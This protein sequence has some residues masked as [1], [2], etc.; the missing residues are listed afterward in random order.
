[1][2]T[3]FP[4]FTIVFQE[5]KSGRWLAW[6]QKRSDIIANGDTKE[7][8]EKNLIELYKSVIEHEKTDPVIPIGYTQEVMPFRI[9]ISRIRVF[10]MRLERKKHR[11]ARSLLI[12]K[13][14][15]KKKYGVKRFIMSP[16]AAN[17]FNHPTDNLHSNFG[18]FIPSEGIKR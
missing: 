13:I 2:I 11:K 18:I 9:R 6:Y 7:D 3:L 16:T 12:R 15:E 10:T 17:L 8:V 1:M 4:P 14:L 5:C